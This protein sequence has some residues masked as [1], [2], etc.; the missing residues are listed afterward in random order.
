MMTGSPTA[1]VLLMA[2]LVS[3]VPTFIGAQEAR[4]I[5]VLEAA[6]ERYA[7]VAELCADF[8]Q[9]LEI[10][11]LGDERT[12]SGQLCQARPNRFTM[13][14]AE[15]A[16]D[17]IVV[18]GESV[19]IFYPSVDDKQVFRFPMADRTGGY[20]FHR[21]F[22]DSPRAKYEVTYEAEEQVDGHPVHRLRLVPRG[23]A[24]YRVAT[25]WIDQGV[26]V[27]RQIRLEE[28]NESIR[29]VTLSN[30]DFDPSGVPDDWFSFTP[31]AGA[32]VIERGR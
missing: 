22:L 7:G 20:D 13:R 30:V 4:G 15:P 24:T 17:R 5:N 14:F 32:H 31:P 11:L 2:V 12:G 19:W 3:A 16:G 6:A 9:R 23:P 29:T 26:P 8:V 1:R 28:E 10:P 27:L 18:D 25:I 21:E